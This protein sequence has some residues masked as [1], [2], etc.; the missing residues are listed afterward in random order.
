MALEINQLTWCEHV[1]KRPAMFTG[2]LTIHGL[3]YLLKHLYSSQLTKLNPS[4]I[5]LE[6]I[7]DNSAILS[8]SGIKKQVT[9]NWSKWNFNHDKIIEIELQT[10]NAL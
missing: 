5:V 8:I 7:D 6:I 9:D 4:L 1:R 2:N 3:V 10:L